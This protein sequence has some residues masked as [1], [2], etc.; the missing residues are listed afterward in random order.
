MGV[1]SSLDDSFK[2][3]FKRSLPLNETFVDRWERAEKLGFGKGTS[4][5]DSSFVLGEVEIGRDCWI[6]PFTLLDGSGNLKIGNNCTISAGA[7]IY[8]HDNVKQTLSAGL[9]PIERSEVNIADNVYV[10]PNAVISKGVNIGKCSV[11]GVNSFVNSDVEEYSIAVGQ[12][13]KVIG[14]VVF[15]GDEIKFKY[16]DSR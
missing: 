11:I 16:F 2:Q 4:I 3:Q 14:K 15:E 9:R 13:A 12:P 1:H 5:Y 6:G 10:A 7:H 8:T